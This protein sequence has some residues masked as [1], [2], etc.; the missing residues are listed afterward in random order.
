[1]PSPS[2][3]SLPRRFSLSIA[4]DRRTDAVTILR[5]L[6]SSS[7]G[8]G[9]QIRPFTPIECVVPANMSISDALRMVGH[10]IDAHLMDAAR[11]EKT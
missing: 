10:S 11:M 9:G 2:V 3:V 5:V 4:V 8:D 6:G 1:M 7:N